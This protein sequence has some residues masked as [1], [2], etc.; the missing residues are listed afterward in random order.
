MFLLTM[1]SSS[2]A[3][4]QTASSCSDAKPDIPRSTRPSVIPQISMKPDRDLLDAK[5]EGY[6]L[7]LDSFPIVSVTLPHH[8]L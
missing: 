4:E 1:D 7:S 2:A 5:F 6:K 3:V 8:G